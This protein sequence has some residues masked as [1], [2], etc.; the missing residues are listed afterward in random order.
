MI[1]FELESRHP[2]FVL[3]YYYVAETTVNE[4]IN[5]ISNKLEFYEFFTL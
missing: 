1:S 5:Y 3:V 4:K 2:Q